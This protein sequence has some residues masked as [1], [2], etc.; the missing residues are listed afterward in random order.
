M[1]VTQLSPTLEVLQEEYLLVE[2]WKKTVAHLRAHN[3][4][5]DTLE[6]DRASV[7]LPRFL[8][9]VADR[10]SDP[11]GFETRPLRF[12]PA[13]K[14]SR[15][16]FTENEDGAYWRPD[17][18]PLGQ[19]P[20]VRPLAHVDLGDQ[21]AATALMLCLADRVETMQGDPT[22]SPAEAAHRTRVLS[23]GNRLLCDVSGDGLRLRHRWGSGALY[24][25]YFED[26]R[27]FVARPS[28]AA[29]AVSGDGE[30]IVIVQSD[31]RNFYDR[32]R[33]AL[34]ARK[35]RALRRAGEHPEFFD[36]AAEVLSWCWDSRDEASANAYAQREDIPSFTDVALPQG[37]AS[38]G[39]FANVVLLGFD[40][41]LRAS[42]STEIFTG[43]YLE[44]VSRYVDDLR[45]V[46][47]LSA[48]HLDLAHIEDAT[49]TWLGL[50]AHPRAGAR[51]LKREDS[52]CRLRHS[53]RASDGPSG[54]SDDADPKRRVRRIRCRWR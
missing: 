32:V 40:R 43:A 52:R 17:V 44:D 5:T 12:V 33:P 21:V 26:Y 51:G 16:T 53:E 3:W 10:L 27:K 48:P 30:R 37:L 47:R 2:A 9:S 13:P 24:R 35:I 25:G 14:S 36:L 8:R 28:A 41:R 23:Y 42:L 15:W 34:L 11:G 49:S 38:A 4:F 45:I 39:F 31:L 6:I 46:L 50:A 54:R 1:P 18:E 7:E 29:E 20:R 19:G 22:G